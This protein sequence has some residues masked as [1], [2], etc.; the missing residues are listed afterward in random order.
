MTR[1]VNSLWSAG[2]MR[3]PKVSNA[4][5]FVL[6]PDEMVAPVLHKKEFNNFFLLEQRWP[7]PP[8]STIIGMVLSRLN[9]QSLSAV[10]LTTK[11]K[12]ERRPAPMLLC[13]KNVLMRRTCV[14]T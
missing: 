9:D 10:V 2:R 1:A 14:S 5:S 7:A 11:K 4:L 6:R 8:N 13:L 3:S 12:E